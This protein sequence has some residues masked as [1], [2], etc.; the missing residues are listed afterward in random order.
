MFSYLKIKRDKELLNKL[1]NV[2][3][4]PHTLDTAAYYLEQ[5]NAKFDDE[6]F[7]LP[8]FL[9]R[10]YFYKNF[11]VPNVPSDY[12]IKPNIKRYQ[13][14]FDEEL[15]CRYEP[16]DYQIPV[17]EEFFNIYNKNNSINGVIQLN[18]GFGKTFLAL[19]LANKLRLKTLI[20]VDETTLVE[21][22]TDRIFEYFPDIDHVGL[23]R[24][25]LID[26]DENTRFTLVYVQSLNSRLRRRDFDYLQKISDQ[27]FGLIIFDECH[28][29][30][31]SDKY[32]K[33]SSLFDTANVIGLSATPYKYALQ[34]LELESSIGDIIISKKRIP[35]KPALYIYEFNSSLFKYIDKRKNYLIQNHNDLTRSRSMYNSSIINSPIYL[36]K[37]VEVTDN[38]LSLKH[39]IIIIANT[40]KQCKL[41]GGAL[42][43]KYPDKIII[44]LHSQSKDDLSQL[45]NADIIVGTYKKC[46]HGFDKKDISAVIFASPYTGRV[47]V[48]QIIGR[49]LR[50]HES[51]QNPVVVYLYDLDYPN[52]FSLKY[53]KNNF[54]NEY[55]D[56]PIFRID[57]NLQV[58]QIV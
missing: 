53:L 26:I 43:E 11:I 17:V 38:L 56:S 32:S 45:Q 5:M 36:K 50:E 57:A 30:S 23:I 10:T 29:V 35:Y 13:P 16:K 24:G 27:N 34:K 21:Q 37:I 1:Y 51:K 31:A 52:L 14:Q 41:I 39:K 40:I 7:Y 18:T 19:Y 4:N 15:E 33:I 55:P 47:S 49:I 9:D 6:Y 3:V 48:P 20:I 44:E 22:W 2:T 28:K 12:I 8:K 58:H 54:L 42:K 46:S 25:D